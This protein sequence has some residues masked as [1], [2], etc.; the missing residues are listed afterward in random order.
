MRCS[1]AKGRPG[2]YFHDP[3]DESHSTAWKV[4]GPKREPIEE[5]AQRCDAARRGPEEERELYL[6]FEFHEGCP[7]VFDEPG[8]AKDERSA[9]DLAVELVKEARA[10]ARKGPLNNRSFLPEEIKRRE[11]YPANVADRLDVIVNLAWVDEPNRMFDLG[12]G[13]ENVPH[14]V[15]KEYAVFDRATR[16]LEGGVCEKFAAVVLGL[17]SCRA[18]AGTTALKIEW[19]NDHHYVVLRIG[20]SRWWVADPWVVNAFV[21]PWT[22]NYFQPRDTKTYVQMIVNAPV[23]VAYGV[24]FKD[25][26]LEKACETAK[27]EVHP[28]DSDVSFTPAHS[29]GNDHNLEIEFE[30]NEEGVEPRWQRAISAT[31]QATRWEPYD[32]DRAPTLQGPDVKPSDFADGESEV[33]AATALEWGPR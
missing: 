1:G 7:L 14:A 21:H 22:N 32:K 9:R 4:W 15:T 16:K 31:G 5:E 26:E 25:S 23:A 3:G 13:L 28:R 11:K 2:P 24:P 27:G 8:D 17:V 12:G 19:I 18:P 33:L 29:F 20:T 6:E 10:L 30:P